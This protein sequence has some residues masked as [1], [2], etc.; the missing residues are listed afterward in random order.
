MVEH[1]S[2]QLDR[3]FHALADE[4]RRALLRDVA[5]A[6]SKSVSELAEPYAMSLAG[7]SKHL[8]VLERASLIRRQRQGTS[9]LVSLTPQALEAAQDWLAF[10][11]NFWN[12]SLDRL[13]TQLEKN[14]SGTSRSRKKVP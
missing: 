12:S 5:L 4:T 11:Q 6:G 8:D 9:R 1:D 13:Q 3:T 2:R 7:V 14:R 10:Y